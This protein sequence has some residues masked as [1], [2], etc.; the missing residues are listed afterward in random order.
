MRKKIYDIIEK[1]D[2]SNVLS[3]TYDIIMIGVIFVSFLPLL[4]RCDNLIYHHIEVVTV[5][6]FIVD[7]ILRW[8]TADFALPEKDGK[9]FFLYPITPLAIIDLLSILPVF[10]LINPT[11]KML[12]FFRLM[13]LARIIKL[14][15]YSENLLILFDVL[16]NQKRLLL[17]VFFIAVF[18]IFLTASII[19]NL[20][21]PVIFPTFFDALY[22]A[23]TALTTVGYGDIYP[24]STIGRI[25]SMVSSLFGVAII[26]LPSGII[27]G[28]FLKVIEDKNATIKGK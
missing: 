15:R 23:T 14:I 28:G 2:D 4:T 22:W 10:G 16:N 1:T 3:T 13:R 17:S 24:V 21:S 8:I 20:D 7:Y 25:I 5:S 26:A 27:T 11:F 9:A 19:Y 18:Y 6:I 12:R